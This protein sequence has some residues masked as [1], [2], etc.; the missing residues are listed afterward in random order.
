ML[1]ADAP[2]WCCWIVHVTFAPYHSL[3]EEHGDMQ[4]RG[5]APLPRAPVPAGRCL[6]VYLLTAESWLIGGLPPQANYCG[7]NGVRRTPANTE[8]G[9]V[10]PKQWLEHH[11]QGR[12]Y[13]PK[14]QEC[15][16]RNVNLQQAKI[17]NRS[18]RIFLEKVRGSGDVAEVRSR[19]PG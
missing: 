2:F 13:D 7:L 9:P 4:T 1:W 14:T 15:L 12:D 19:L 16:A 10:N 11:L 5:Q 18:L 3:E 17:R 6:L 8:T